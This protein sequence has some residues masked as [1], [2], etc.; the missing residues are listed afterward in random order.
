MLEPVE[1]FLAFRVSF[2]MVRARAITCT[3]AS[4]F[5]GRSSRCRS[6]AI[7]TRHS[8]GS[9]FLDGESVLC[10]H[11]STAI[12]KYLSVCTQDGRSSPET[13][14]HHH[15]I[16]RKGC[17]LGLQHHPDHRRVSDVCHLELRKPYLFLRYFSFQRTFESL[18]QLSS[19]WIYH[20]W[21]FHVHKHH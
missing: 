2:C 11:A 10:W 14:R 12:L 13:V 7:A 1:A 17:G 15:Q 9:P 16:C 20:H 21:Y 3:H 19:A 6:A 18:Q 5:G 4:F 8:F